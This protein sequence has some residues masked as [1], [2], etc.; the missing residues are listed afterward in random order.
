MGIR[1]F[2]RRILGR[3]VASEIGVL[4]H[5]LAR[6]VPSGVMV[7]V[8]AH[9][10]DS[11]WPFL[12]SGWTVWAFEPDPEN[13]RRLEGLRHRYPG[14]HIDPRAVTDSDGGAATL[15][16]SSISSGLSTLRPFHESHREGIQ[17]ETVSL[18][19]FC[20]EEG[21]VRIDFL[22]VDTEGYDLPVLQGHDWETARPTVVMCEYED[23]RTEATG[24][25][26]RDLA[27]L[28]GGSG[29][30]LAVSEWYPVTDYG[31]THRWR[32]VFPY[33][34]GP[35]DAEAWGNLV[36]FTDEGTM[37][38]FMDLLARVMGTRR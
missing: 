11:C 26:S 2:I 25:S 6:D 36:A 16:T 15:Y 17:V 34:D 23:R 3:P 19:R 13:T 12:D 7:D 29:Y 5:L 30:H 27:D 8:G 10:G 32:R 20:R 4:H 31:G 28:L 9:T 22:K 14:L 18:A 21:V 1:Q 35:L 24:Y 38:R 33:G 37:E